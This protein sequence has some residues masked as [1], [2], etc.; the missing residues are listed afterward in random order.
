MYS[1]AVVAVSSPSDRMVPLLNRAQA[2]LKLVPLFSGSACGA[3]VLLCQF[4]CYLFTC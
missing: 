1:K 3:V 4:I 2:L